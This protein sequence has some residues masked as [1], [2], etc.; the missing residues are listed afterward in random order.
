MELS[1]WLRFGLY[2]P[3]QPLDGARC[4]KVGFS[5][6]PFRLST[7]VEVDEMT[8][9]DHYV[10]AICRYEPVPSVEDYWDLPYDFYTSVWEHGPCSLSGWITNDEGWRASD[11]DVAQYLLR[12]P[13]SIHHPPTWGQLRTGHIEGAT[14]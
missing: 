1:F 10:R 11:H 4:F 7:T 5:T 2:L 9:R 12:D 8:Y 14:W 6:Q 13:R 3:A